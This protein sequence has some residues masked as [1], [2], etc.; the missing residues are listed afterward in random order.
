MRDFLGED[1]GIGQVLAVFQ[2][3]IL[4]PEDVEVGF[5]AFDD[6]VVV[7]VLKSRA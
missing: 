4:Q 6:L 3:V 1:L 7:E 2:R 5:V